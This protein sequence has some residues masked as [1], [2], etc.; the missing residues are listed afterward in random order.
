M[1]LQCPRSWRFRRIIP[2]SVGDET[3]VKLS[4]ACDIDFLGEEW[5]ISAFLWAGAVW[6]GRSGSTNVRLF[7]MRR[8]AHDS[9]MSPWVAFNCPIILRRRC[10]SPSS[11]HEAYAT[12]VFHRQKRRFPVF[13]GLRIRNHSHELHGKSKRGAVLARLP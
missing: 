10:M 2:D 7:P 13:V 12:N 3:N 1:N 8:V 5:N 4:T 9:N 11:R 6:D